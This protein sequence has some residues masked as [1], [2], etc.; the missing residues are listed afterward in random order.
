MNSSTVVFIIA[1]LS[2]LLLSLIIG[3]NR[4]SKDSTSWISAKKQMGLLVTTSSI[5]ATMIGGAVF[6]AVVIMGY[7]NGIVGIYIGIAYALGLFAVGLFSDKILK[8]LDESNSETIFHFISIRLGAKTGKVYSIISVILFTFAVAGQIIA[9]QH[10]FKS[11]PGMNN[12]NIATT[13]AVVVSIVIV[14]IY[15]YYGGLRKDMIS[16]V[17]QII[18]MAIGLIII[19][20]LILSLPGVS[21]LKNINP[22]YYTVGAYGPLFLIGALLM[23][24]PMLLVRADLWQ[25]LRAAKSNKVAKWSFYI[26]A[27][28]VALSFCLFTYIGMLARGLNVSTNSN[29]IIGILEKG[30]QKSLSP[31]IID[32]ILLA[33][34]GAVISTLDSLLNM[35]GIS[36]VRAYSKKD[37]EPERNTPVKKY[38]ISTIII[39]M[40]SAVIISI[41]S[42]DIVD[43][44]VAAVSFV[45]VIALPILHLLFGYEPSQKGA[46]YGMLIGSLI[47]SIS[48]L[49]V[50]KYAFIPGV[51]FGW[52]IYLVVRKIEKNRKHE[53]K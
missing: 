22:K 29:I 41:F 45:M 5:V 34:V 47:M 30:Y 48:W 4:K 9:F 26:S 1:I 46:Y 6:V 3:K 8:L 44:F 43:V 13:M 21:I 16:D 15:T 20:P 32:C 14:I 7:E 2:M 50:P 23:M 18:Y 28:I 19:I 31:W 51:I 27:P 49:V 36:L 52:A 33:F 24:G 12:G 10:Y 35:A 25:R 39:V 17:V 38:R 37:A 53:Q 42:N 11:I 40:L